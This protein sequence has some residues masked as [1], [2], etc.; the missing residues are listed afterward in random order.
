MTENSCS[1]DYFV[2]NLPYDVTE[3]E[4]KDFFKPACEVTHCRLK[5]TKLGIKSCHGYIRFGENLNDVEA[6]AR[7]ERLKGRQL[8]IELVENGKDDMTDDE[9]DDAIDATDGEG[10]PPWEQNQKDGQHPIKGSTKQQTD[11]QAKRR[12]KWNSKKGNE[13]IEIINKKGVITKQGHAILSNMHM[14]DVVLLVQKMQQLVRL[15]PQTAIKFLSNNKS[16]CYSL[17]HAL[18]LLGI[19]NVE[20]N[21]LSEEDIT[22]VKFHALKNKFQFLC[23]DGEEEDEVDTDAYPLGEQLCHRGGIGSHEVDWGNMDRGDAGGRGSDLGEVSNGE[24]PPWG[25]PNYDYEQNGRRQLYERGGR[26]NTV[27][28]D[29]PSSLKHIRGKNLPVSNLKNASRGLY[30]TN[31]STSYGVNHNSYAPFNHVDVPSDGGQSG[32]PADR[33]SA[34]GEVER[35][36]V[37]GQ[38]GRPNLHGTVGSAYHPRQQFSQLTLSM[39]NRRGGTSGYPLQGSYSN[40]YTMKGGK[41]KNKNKQINKQK[42]KQ[43]NKTKNSANMMPLGNR[44]GSGNMFSS[45]GSRPLDYDSNSMQGNAHPYNYE[46]EFPSGRNTGLYGMRGVVDTKTEK[47]T[48]YG[49]YYA[50]DGVT[51]QHGEGADPLDTQINYSGEMSNVRVKSYEGNQTEGGVF[52]IGGQSTSSLYWRGISRKGNYQVDSETTQRD[53]YMSDHQGENAAEE[54]HLELGKRLIQK[55]NTSNNQRRGIKLIDRNDRNEQTKEENVIRIKNVDLYNEVEKTQEIYLSS[56]LKALLKKVNMSL[57]DI[58]YAEEDLVKEVINE[59][60]ILENILISKYADMVNWNRDQVLR[61]LS[62]RK[63]LK[64]R[65]YNING[66][67]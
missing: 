19:L 16:I 32:Y 40:K 46:E 41:L 12:N 43:K 52:Q 31:Q 26:I 65:G 63:S 54:R 14:Y 60:P 28:M 29:T 39:N 55:I 23:V 24:N 2:S 58:P 49:N 22:R 6:Y 53:S 33:D 9:E 61:V 48:Y 17:I 45:G 11:E 27:K 18:F 64:S 10:F 44:A 8:C 15:S 56:S 51:G 25:G 5:R 42:S 38:M 7:R 50:S 62:I 34:F 4:L 57:K 37:K 36:A 21:P 13:K 1:I 3:E 47:E 20:M 67:I 66:V 35:E 30:S 59:K